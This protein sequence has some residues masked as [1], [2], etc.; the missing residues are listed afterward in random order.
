MVQLHEKK[1]KK[2]VKLNKTQQMRNN[3]RDTTRRW[4][5]L[6]LTAKQVSSIDLYNLEDE[7]NNGYHDGIRQRKNSSSTSCIFIVEK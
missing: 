6:D 1:N 5:N 2:E 3:H 4:L 7:A